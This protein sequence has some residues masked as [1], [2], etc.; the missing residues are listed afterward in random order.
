MESENRVRITK[1]GYSNIDIEIE[2]CLWQLKFNLEMFIENQIKFENREYDNAGTR[3]L[4]QRLNWKDGK[5]Y[6]IKRLLIKVQVRCERSFQAKNFFKSFFLHFLKNLRN[7]ID[8]KSVAKWKTK[9]VYE[10]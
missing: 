8:R 2:Q 10:K 5:T 7:K 6:Q 3:K 4:L 1:I 9:Q